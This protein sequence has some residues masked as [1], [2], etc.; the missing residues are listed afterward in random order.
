MG[1]LRSWG[2]YLA[3][4]VVGLA[5][6]VLVLSTGFIG[7]FLLRLAA[8]LAPKP[9]QPRPQEITD[10]D[11]RLAKVSANVSDRL[12]PDSDRLAVSHHLHPRSTAERLTEPAD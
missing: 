6:G 9:E 8:M 10:H 1:D 12:E 5:P 4:L 11:L 2:G 7:Q 3:A